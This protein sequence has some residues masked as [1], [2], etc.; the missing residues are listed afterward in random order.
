MGYSE[1]QKEWL[2]K[3]LPERNNKHLKREILNLSIRHYIHKYISTGR[4]YV[5]VIS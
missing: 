5:L 1:K 3:S 4:F 2:V